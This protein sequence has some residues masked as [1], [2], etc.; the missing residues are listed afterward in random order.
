[1]QRKVWMVLLAWL[2]AATQVA[3]EARIALII[4]N[5]VYTSVN[6]L[7][8]STAD[9]RLMADSLTA[10]G[11]DVTLV[12]EG[13]FSEMRTAI[14]QFGAKLRGAG[15]DA[16]GLFYYA[17]HGVQSF[18]RNYFLPVDTE[19]SNAADISLVAIE[20]DS[21]LQQMRSAGNKTNIV[22]LDACRN[23]PFKKVLDLGENGLA[24]MNAPTGTFL[25]FATSPGAAA[26]DGGGDHS[27]FTEALAAEIQQ[28]G[29]SLE[30][31]FKEV[32]R[33]VM[34]K[35]DNKQT[36]WDT[37]SL[38]ADFYFVPV[39]QLSLEEQAEQ[40]FWEATKSSNDV[41]QIAIFMKT[42]PKS[43]HIE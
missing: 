16:T 33:S 14:S 5:S 3:A 11:F 12:S 2:F 17:G 15:R 26:Y 27:P 25:A 22:I 40:Q 13:T 31:V 38:T 41:V 32:R 6:G 29:V 30:Q 18:G 28:P 36:P 42:Y 7:P 37:S 9:A 10:I 39:K 19:L 34:A 21:V 1:M 24:E 8:N 43:V 35:T 20:A 4:G 23:N